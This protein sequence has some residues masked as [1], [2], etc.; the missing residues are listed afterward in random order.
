MAQN[1]KKISK[2]IFIIS[3]FVYVLLPD[4]FDNEN[5]IQLP[6]STVNV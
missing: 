1:L 2:F 3:I 5:S 4:K 6:N